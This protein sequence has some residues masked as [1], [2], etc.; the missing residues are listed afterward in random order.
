MADCGSADEKRVHARRRAG[1][2]KAGIDL[3]QLL[4]PIDQAELGAK[5]RVGQGGLMGFGKGR[6]HRADAALK[7]VILAGGDEARAQHRGQR[8]LAEK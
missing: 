1:L 3:H 5:S 2:A 6:H 8:A 7:Q 4:F